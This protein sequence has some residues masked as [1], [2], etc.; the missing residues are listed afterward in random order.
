ME[1]YEYL[2]QNIVDCSFIYTMKGLFAFGGIA[3]H[4]KK[5]VV[6]NRSVYHF[7]REKLTWVAVAELD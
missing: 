5:K 3:R 4:S 2:P 1:E 7:N 6:F